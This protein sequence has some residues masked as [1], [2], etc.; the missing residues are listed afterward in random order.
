MEYLEEK[1]RLSCVVME[2][3]RKRAGSLFRTSCKPVV[4]FTTNKRYLK[5]VYETVM[6]GRCNYYYTEMV[7]FKVKVKCD[8]E[9]GEEDRF[10]VRCIEFRMEDMKGKR[11]M[12]DEAAIVL[13]DAI[14][15]GER[16]NK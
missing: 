1:L 14:E 13:L 4:S 3:N 9:D 12:K 10:Y 15:Y 16:K 2:P 11:P 7:K 6:P 8:W 5:A